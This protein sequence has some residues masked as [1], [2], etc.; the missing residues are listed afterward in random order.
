[1]KADNNEIYSTISFIPKNPSFQAY[2]DGWTA[3]G[4][5]FS[6]FMINTYVIVLPKVL[7]AVL[8]TIITA[9][10]FP[11]SSSWVNRCCLQC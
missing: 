11:D 1:M 6:R 10:G 5:D 9:Y 7:G 2:I 3:T 8:S 4:F